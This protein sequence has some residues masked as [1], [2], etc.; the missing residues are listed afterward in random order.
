MN[1]LLKSI[2]YFII[3]LIIQYGGLMGSWKGVSWVPMMQRIPFRTLPASFVVSPS[4]LSVAAAEVDSLVVPV[5]A[6]PVA[7]C[8]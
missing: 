7:S 4:V 2:N 6:T 8:P 3:Q 1:C 5:S